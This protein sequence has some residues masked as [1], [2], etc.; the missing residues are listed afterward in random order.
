M[1]AKF[2]T[3][4][5]SNCIYIWYRT[6]SSLKIELSICNL[7]EPCNSKVTSSFFWSVKVTSCPFETTL[8][9]VCNIQQKTSA[10]G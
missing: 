10:L 8:I 3:E 6:V 7:M 5:C 9:V 4:Q 2:G 1:P